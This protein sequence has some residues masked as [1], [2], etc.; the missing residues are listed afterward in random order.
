M[1]YTQIIANVKV[2]K[3]EQVK[4]YISG[5]NKKVH[6]SDKTCFKPGE[7]VDILINENGTEF[8][9]IPN[10]KKSKAQGPML[11]TST[12]GC[13]FSN[14]EFMESLNI[15]NK[16]VKGLVGTKIKHDKKIAYKF[17][18]PKLEDDDQETST[19]TNE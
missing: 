12:S 11:S 8:L 5:K 19:L 1:A 2:R 15:Q 6:I 13:C 10:D 4:I 16:T 3:P 17:I 14:K 7:R 18:M 9:L